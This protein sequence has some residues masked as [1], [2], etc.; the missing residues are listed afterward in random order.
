MMTAGQIA[1]ALD[2]KEVVVNYKASDFT[3]ASAETNPLAKLEFT[4]HKGSFRDMKLQNKMY[5]SEQY[6]P[7]G[8]NFVEKK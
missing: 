4:K 3:A 2:V 1:K 7:S 6:F 5:E 8:V